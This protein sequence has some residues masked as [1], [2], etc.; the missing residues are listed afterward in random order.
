MSCSGK[1]PKPELFRFSVSKGSPFQLQIP[2]NPGVSHA[3]GTSVFSL[4]LT[5]EEA[6]Q[7]VDTIESFG[8][9]TRLYPP[10][11]QTP[12]QE[13][14]R[15]TL[16]GL[17]KEDTVWPSASCPECAW[18]DPLLAG[19]P[20]GRLGWPPEAITAFA[21]NPKPQQDSADCPVPH[22]W[23]TSDG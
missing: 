6:A 14:E 9:I 1:R 22:L 20:C 5:E 13:K 7:V 3:G 23:R 19:E 21:A 16:L 12:E 8:C 17:G 18:F 15:H 4:V 10:T 11:R 2:G